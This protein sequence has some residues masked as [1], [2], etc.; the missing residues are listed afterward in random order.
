MRP[1]FGVSL[2]NT[3]PENQYMIAQRSVLT[4]AGVAAIAAL[5][6]SGCSTATKETASSMTDKA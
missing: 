6:L 3:D 5:T 1:L 4:A 2:I